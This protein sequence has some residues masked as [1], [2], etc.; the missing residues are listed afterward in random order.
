MS[1][2]VGEVNTAPAL[3]AIEDQT[4]AEGETLS[5]TVTATDTDL[6]AN[7]LTFSLGT[8]ESVGMV[9]DTSTGV[10]SWTPEK[11]QSGSTYDA[12]VIV[13][14][15]G[16]PPLQDE[17]S[18]VVTVTGVN[19]APVLA[20]PAQ[21]DLVEDTP[22]A[23]GGVSVSDLDSGTEVIEVSLSVGSGQLSVGTV[24][25]V[26]V[27]GGN[28]SQLVVNGVLAAVNESLASLSYQG[29]ENFFGEDTLSIGANDLGN[30]GEGGPLTAQFE[31]LLVIAPV[32][33]APT[34]GAVSDQSTLDGVAVGSVVFTVA[35]V[36]NAPETL[37][38]SGASSNPG[39]IAPDGIT[40]AGTGTDRTVS[41]QPTPDQT[42]I[43]T[44]TLE[45]SDG[46]GATTNTSFDVAVGV[47]APVITQDPRDKTTLDRGS[48]VF[49]VGVSGTSPLSYQWLRD[50][51]EIAG[52]TDAALSLSSV[53]VNEAGPYTVRVSNAAG[54]VASQAATLIVN[55]PAQISDAQQDT[56]IA[57]GDP[58]NLV[59]NASGTPPLNYQWYFNGTPIDG[60]T[61]VSFSIAAAQLT[62]TG[63]YT[64]VVSNPVG[65]IGGPAFNVTVIEP[66]LIVSEPQ[67]IDAKKGDQVRMSVG[68]GGTGPFKYQWE[69]NGAVFR[70][71]SKPELI[72]PGVQL[73]AA[74]SYRVR[75]SNLVSE[76]VSQEATL[77][78][79][80]QAQLSGLPKLVQVAIGDDLVLQVSAVGSP[81]FTFQWQLNG[82]N[83]DGAITDTYRIPN[84]Q[85][86]DGG[87]YT[88]TVTD[89]G[90]A[91][92]SNLTSVIVITPNLGLADDVGSA[93]PTSAL[94]GDGSGNNVGAGS[95]AGEPSHAGGRPAKRSVWMAWNSPGIGVASFGTR[96]SGFDTILA[97]YKGSPE[98]LQQ[99]ASDEDGG[100][101]LTSA[102]SFNTETGV[103]YFVAVDGF[104]GA[105]GAVALRWD[106]FQTAEPLPVITTQP[107]SQTVLLGQPVEFSVVGD[108]S[109]GS[110]LSYQ[111]FLDGEIIADASGAA[112]SL[113]SV[114]A[115]DVGDYTVQV[116]NAGG[117]V[118]STPAILQINLIATGSEGTG[119]DAVDKIGSSSQT[120]EQI[121]VG[122]ASVGG[123]D[124]SASFISRR[125]V[126]PIQRRSLLQGTRGEKL[127]SSRN[128]VKDAGEPNH[129]R[130][131][132]GASTW[133]I[134]EA[135][136]NGA[137]R[138]STE[139]SSYD[140]VLAV[141]TS[142]TLDVDYSKLVE[143]SCNDNGGSDGKTSVIEFSVQAGTRYYL[144]VDGVNGEKGIVH[145]TYEL[146]QTPVLSQPT[147][148]GVDTASGQV[149]ETQEN[150]AVSVGAGVEFR[151][152]IGGLP[153][154]ASVGY[155][156]RRN[157]IDVKG[158]TN[159]RLLL[160]SVSQ[161][162]SGN[163][164]VEVTTFAGTVESQ[165][166]S[167]KVAEPIQL[168]LSPDDQ[169][170]V[171]GRSAYFAVVP[172]GA[173]PFE[174]QWSLNG[175]PV[176]GLTT[177]AVLVL[178]VQQGDAG[179]Y[180]VAIADGISQTSASAT[181][182]VLEGLLIVTQPVGLDL[183]AG[184]NAELTVSAQGV[185]PLS[186]QWQHNG[187]DI[188]GATG[189]VLALQSVRV[190]QAGSY[191]VV[192]SNPFA[193][194]LSQPAVVNVVPVESR[195]VSFERLADRTIELV[196]TGPIGARAV[197]E[198]SN[199][200]FEW[201]ELVNLPIVSTPFRTID[202]AAPNFDARFYRVRVVP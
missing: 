126:R 46:E 21:V 120:G 142:P 157:G 125:S 196:L 153:S 138:V 166:S 73:N 163:Y 108:N 49:T 183:Q 36:D 132:G 122:P 63:K 177:S 180:E 37:S 100:G 105:Q 148:F 99:V 65:P 33:D 62:D 31:V 201:T 176:N 184:Q 124:A 114:G 20:G 50:G 147:W 146:S 130:V 186:Y 12:T 127:F 175:Q 29:Q 195:I 150:P 179:V 19:D 7:N 169:T 98:N 168:L 93:S 2:E 104:E 64:V 160:S 197:V 137:L 170:V 54:A 69:F 135:P 152:G 67:N 13:T 18:F 151:L 3:A 198:V 144:V 47:A 23:V 79:T 41:V 78:V 88:V 165:E 85:S 113:A 141:Y 96:G 81:P 40:L 72:L 66:I 167:F 76:A 200:L 86:T 107:E 181:L 193:T 149:D 57:V 35:D 194:L 59:V 119:V 190:D 42:G 80:G 58:L 14:D 32:N 129:C 55:V 9:I 34:I 11:T 44:I 95:E 134:Y 77:T 162:D 118:T 112:L 39:L 74:G 71:T 4:F 171:A 111:W 172:S 48:V 185:D 87:T 158:G 189:A 187:V 61:E 89:G 164:T 17:K 139:G 84:V 178:D 174:Y 154:S 30:T 25:G 106:W 133:F 83:I 192:V 161:V 128:A 191:T 27:S 68:V 70:E 6:P 136:Q 115:L 156:W 22:G 10:L 24:D 97:A 101:F 121:V 91:T 143:V 56:V 16:T 5:L 28:S 8:G 43:A 75:V 53:T 90:G 155:Q 199:D 15:D 202:S 117:I 92:T 131:L 109:G 123:E 110:I 45:V 26:S 103:T 52:A 145:F 51:V 82:V 159:A 116:S 102:T 182:T 38:V 140:T 60:A 94:S 1:V 188:A 173:G